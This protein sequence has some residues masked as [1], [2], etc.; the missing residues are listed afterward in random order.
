MFKG[1]PTNKDRKLV[2]WTMHNSCN[3]RIFVKEFLIHLGP[4]VYSFH[5][6]RIIF[7]CVFRVIRSRK[8]KERRDTAHV[9]IVKGI[10]ER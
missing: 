9:Q 8:D 6:W 10:Y 3:N 5:V 2:N 1:I 4:V 7:L